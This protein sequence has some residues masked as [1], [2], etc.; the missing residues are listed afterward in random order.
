MKKLFFK[1]IG[2]LT[3][4]S[5]QTFAQ[6]G[7]LIIDSDSLFSPSR[8]STSL[9]VLFSVA[10]VG[11]V[12]FLLMST[13]CFIRVVIILG[14][15]RGAIGTQQAPPNPVI[16]SL[17]LFLTIFVMT[18]VFEGIYQDVLVPYNDGD[19]TQIQALK[20]GGQKLKEFM[21]KHTSEKDLGLFIEFSR[22]PKP[23]S[24]SQTPIYVVIP[25][26]ILSELKTAFQIGF[27]LYIPFVVIDLIVSNVL[28]SLGMFMLSPAMVSTPFKLLLFVL[29]DGWNLIVKGLLTSYII[30]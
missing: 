22:I 29:T 2:L 8:F 15:I 28:L 1:L 10:I 9:N 13:T 14:M 6:E 24:L 17:A 4:L 23:E 3:I 16:V 30:K 11:F 26:F 25:S 5:I 7:G 12:P 18:P 21:L 27:I 20:D 19:I